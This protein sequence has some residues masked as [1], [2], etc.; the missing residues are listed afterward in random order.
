[1]P[2]RPP[3]SL[4]PFAITATCVALLLAT[5]AVAETRPFRLAYLLTSDDS[6]IAEVE[7]V[8]EPTGPGRWRFSSRVEPSGILATLVGGTIREV[9]ELEQSGARLRPLDYRFERHGLGRDREVTVHFDWAR[10]RVVN[11]VNDDRWSMRVPDETL[12]KHALVLAVSADLGAGTLAASYPVADGGRLKTYTFERLAEERLVTPL[13]VVD[14]VKLR[15]VR[16]GGRPATLFWHAPD[17]DH[18][19][20]RIER[21]DGEGRVLRMA[22]TRFSTGAGR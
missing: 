11:E 16:P 15:R 4:P 13:G 20:V 2:A 19:P 18:L 22:L 21:R 14:T 9:T 17:F 8:L 3:R 1:M 12:D 6:E 5:V 7:Q 10:G